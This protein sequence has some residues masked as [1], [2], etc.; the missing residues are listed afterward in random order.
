MKISVS[1]GMT[2]GKLSVTLR[3]SADHLKGIGGTGIALKRFAKLIVPDITRGEM[4]VGV[5]MVTA[6][7]PNKPVSAAKPGSD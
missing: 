1:I 2:V 3:V 7:D 6:P 5:S 4:F